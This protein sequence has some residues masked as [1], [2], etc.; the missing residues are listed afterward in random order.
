MDSE[1]E[2]LGLGVRTKGGTKSGRRDNKKLSR[3]D[4]A[5]K[6]R[7]V[8]DNSKAPPQ[9][10]AAAGRTLAEMEGLIGKHQAPPNR[11]ASQPVG[12]LSRTE[13]ELELSRLRTKCGV[14]H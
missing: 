4:V 2:R 8:L 7:E 13:L 6:L 9:A 12:Q 11:G 1:L 14:K 10:R 3:Y 5:A